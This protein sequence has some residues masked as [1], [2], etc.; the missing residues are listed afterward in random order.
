M[1]GKLPLLCFGVLAASLLAC[2]P[3]HI[4]DRLGENGAD[5]QAGFGSGGGGAGGIPGSGGVGGSAAGAPGAAGASGSG[6]MGGTS[7]TAG[8]ADAGLP[9]AGSPPDQGPDASDAPDDTGQDPD[10]AEEPLDESLLM[11]A[12]QPGVPSTNLTSAGTLD[13]HHFGL[14]GGSGLNRK[15]NGQGIIGFS[16]INITSFGHYADRPVTFSWSDGQTVA[17]ASNVPDGIVAG[18]TIGR[19]FEL[20]VA[21]DPNRART[22]RVF[23]GVWRGGGR[24]TAQL[25]GAATT[26]SDNTL[27]ATAPGADR[28]YT[29]TFQPTTETGVLTVRWTLDSMSH[30]YGNVTL[31]AAT[32]SD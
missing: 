17:S 31:Q 19:G 21:G 1:A 29:V 32:L 30:M 24:F 26:F 12:H 3:N 8:A 15:G 22:L 14:G 4:V 5:A 7:G 20:R 28:I 2:G 11:V 23:V 10:L 25:D 18:D 27:T 16:G 13:W 9:D 6:A